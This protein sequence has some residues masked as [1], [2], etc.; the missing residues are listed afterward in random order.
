M[1]VNQTNLLS[2]QRKDDSEVYELALRKQNSPKQDNHRYK[3]YSAV[4][5]GFGHLGNPEKY[6]D[7]PALDYANII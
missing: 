5:T 2:S 1:S 7:L 6:E 3:F 4:K